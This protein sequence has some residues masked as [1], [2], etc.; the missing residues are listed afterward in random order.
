MVCDCLGARFSQSRKVFLGAG[1]GP[2]RPELNGLQREGGTGGSGWAL[3]CPGAPAAG[4][5]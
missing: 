2:V 4:T 5:G 3:S 1:A